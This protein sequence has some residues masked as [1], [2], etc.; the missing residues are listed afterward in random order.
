MK[1]EVGD[2]IL[3]RQMG[4][5]EPEFVKGRVTALF[6]GINNDD[7][8]GLYYRPLDDQGHEV[9]PPLFA[10]TYSLAGVETASKE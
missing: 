2:T 1:I 10:Y 8:R 3:L 5:G 4:E 7:W 9:G 6:P